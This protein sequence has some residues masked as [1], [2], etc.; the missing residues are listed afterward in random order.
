MS[1]L[2]RIPR[3]W[4]VALG[5]ALGWL[6]WVLRIRRRVMLSNLALAFPERTEA[7]RRRIARD[8]CRQLGAA[9]AEFIRL[10]YASREELERI[11]VYEGWENLER[12][13]ARGKGV[14]ACT[15]HFGNFEVLAAAHS[16]RGIPVTV[17]TRGMRGGTKGDA[18]WLATRRRSGL[19]DLHVGPGDTYKAA[20][21]AL[22]SGRVLGYV[23]DQSE[24]A[25][26]A[27]YPTFFGVPCATSPT[28]A[29]LAW[30]TGAPAVFVV[31]MPLGDGR[32]RVVLE[33]PFDPP[34]TGDR[35]RDATAFMQE[36]NDRLE[37]HVRAHPE[38]WY[39]LHRRWK[40]RGPPAAASPPAAAAG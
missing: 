21:A 6:L 23:I 9:A 20:S 25:R 4:L 33:G 18:L 37:R 34:R 26:S 16:L 3:R 28:P 22:R 7:A 24:H 11:F 2:A 5:A 39:W 1:L 17:V 36:M 38:H 12:A 15:A 19:E 8:T 10:P 14:I 40:R 29:V 13:R 31:S 35:E 30:R 27:V 32:H